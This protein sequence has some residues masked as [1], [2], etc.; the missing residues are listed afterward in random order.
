MK[1]LVFRNDR[2]RQAATKLAG[3]VSPKA[4]VGPYA[5]VRLE[6]VA[7]PTPPAPDWVV[8]DTVLSGLCGRRRLGDVF[9]SHRRE[10]SG[11]CLRR[12]EAGEFRCCL[13]D[14]VVADHEC[15]HQ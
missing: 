2:A 4:F 15:L 6:D 14:A 7:E 13:T 1:A 5:P 8:C 9:E 11:E 3:F 10:R 12:R